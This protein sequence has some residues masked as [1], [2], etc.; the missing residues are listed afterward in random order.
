MGSEW[1]PIYEME[2]EIHVWNHQPVWAIE[3][4]S[5]WIPHKG[6]S[7]FTEFTDWIC[8]LYLIWL[9]VFRLPLWIIWISWDD[10]S[11]YIE[12]EKPCSKPPTSYYDLPE[13][14]WQSPTEVSIDINVNPELINHGLL[15]RDI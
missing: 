5:L 12:K 3:M 7:G 2:N 11:Q 9:V 13:Q 15:F 8:L 4:I 6:S 10:F 1:Q 14:S